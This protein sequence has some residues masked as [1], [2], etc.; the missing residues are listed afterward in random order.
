MTGA[1]RILVS[2]MIASVPRQGGATWAVLQYL[3][4][5]WTSGRWAPLTGGFAAI[6]GSVGIGVAGM[7]AKLV[8]GRLRDHLEPDDFQGLHSLMGYWWSKTAKWGPVRLEALRLSVIILS[9]TFFAAQRIAPLTMLGMSLALF[10]DDVF[11]LW[12]G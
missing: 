2:G 7:Y 5:R 10:W 8:L 12:Q 1:L 9:S 4:W 6:S 3:L 11:R